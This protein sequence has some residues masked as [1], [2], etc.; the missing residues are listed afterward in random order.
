[1]AEF[2]EILTEFRWLKRLAAA[3]AK[4]VRLLS[5]FAGLRQKTPWIA[6]IYF[7]GSSR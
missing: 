3:P 2:E 7:S 4:E 6:F 5:F 1:M